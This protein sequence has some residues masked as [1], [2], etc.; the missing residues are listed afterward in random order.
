VIATCRNPN[1]ASGLNDLAQ[2]FGKDRVLIRSLD[3]TNPSA[4]QE[5]YSNLSASGI[6]S[7]D[8]LIG[9]AGVSIPD[10]PYDPILTTKVE[11]MMNVY[12]TNCVG[13]LLLLQTFHPMLIKSSLKLAVIMTSNLASLSYTLTEGGGQTAYRASKAA[14]NMLGVLYAK[15]EQVMK[16]G[17]K[18]ILI[19]PG[20]FSPFLILSFS[21]VLFISIV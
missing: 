6:N 15:D 2:Q 18:V 14:L 16:A 20:W 21:S 12:R 8:V 7:I 10:H 5:L 4:F 9:N 19:H 11:D 1:W 3:A 13:N 17:V